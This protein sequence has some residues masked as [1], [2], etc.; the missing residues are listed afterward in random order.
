MNMNPVVSQGER[1]VKLSIPQD[2][3]Q[4]L[5]NLKLLRPPQTFSSIVTAA[6]SLYFRSLGSSRSSS[7]S[8]IREDKLFEVNKNTIRGLS[9]RRIGDNMWLMEDRNGFVFVH[10]V[11]P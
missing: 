8:S 7:L 5:V 4:R 3:Y 1:S 10:I 2:Y 9:A 11:K 6:L